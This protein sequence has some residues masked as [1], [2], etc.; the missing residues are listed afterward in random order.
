MASVTTPLKNLICLMQ[1][2][3]MALTR[4]I[5]AI[6]FVLTFAILHIAWAI[7]SAVSYDFRT[8][9]ILNDEL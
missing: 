2:A 7:L 9:S 3:I 4:K 6:L 8:Y 1:A 5:K